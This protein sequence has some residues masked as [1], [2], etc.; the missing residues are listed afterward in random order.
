MGAGMSSISNCVIP[1]SAGSNRFKRRRKTGSRRRSTFLLKNS[2]TENLDLDAVKWVSDISFFIN[3]GN[4][5][6]LESKLFAKYHK[7]VKTY[8]SDGDDKKKDLEKLFDM[9]S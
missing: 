7:N 9:G 2:M 6:L 1:N 4:T 8:N 3:S 5:A